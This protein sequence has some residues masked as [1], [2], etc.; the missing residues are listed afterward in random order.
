M[1][2]VNMFK[3]TR[4][5]VVHVCVHVQRYICRLVRSAH[6]NILTDTTLLGSYHTA[7]DRGTY[8]TTDLCY[9]IYLNQL[10]VRFREATEIR[11]RKQHLQIRNFR[12]ITEKCK[13]IAYCF[14]VYPYIFST[15]RF[16]PFVQL[17]PP[18]KM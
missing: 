17:Y 1:G 8:I 4:S 10:L 12:A 5:L 7:G 11:E 9:T 15:C 13:F 3:F 14:F 6:Y 16:S 2:H 18:G